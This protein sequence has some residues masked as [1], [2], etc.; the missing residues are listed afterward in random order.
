[1]A[2]IAALCDEFVA[3]LDRLDRPTSRLLQPGLSREAVEAAC[4]TL[5][6]VVPG[7]VVELYTWRDGIPWDGRATFGEMWMFPTY[8]VMSPQ[9]AVECYATLLEVNQEFPGSWETN[10]LPIFASGCGPFL[11][12]RCTNSVTDD[13]EIV[14]NDA[15]SEDQNIV[16][17]ESLD[18]MLTTINACLDAGA[19]FVSC[20]GCGIDEDSDRFSEIARKFNRNFAT[21]SPRDEVPRCARRQS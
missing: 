17:Y 20:D 12:I 7:S 3:R 6:F 1:V 5:P 4:S 18:S 10:C 21:G 8:F 14:C 2:R 9:K 15:E 11:G 13:G 19:L 16:I